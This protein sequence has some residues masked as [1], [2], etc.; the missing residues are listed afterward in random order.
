LFA[1]T[2]WP[3]NRDQR[4]LVLLMASLLLLPLVTAP[5]IGVKLTSLWTMSAWFLLPIV[6]LAPS[7]ATLSRLA[8]IRV[9]G[10]VGI[11]TI[12]C[13]AA[14]PLVAWT[15]F[16]MKSNDHRRFYPVAAKEVTRAWHAA[17]QRRLSIV[18]GDNL[19]PAVSFYSPDHPDSMITNNWR[20]WPW[21]TPDRLAQE[22]WVGV[23][24][25][26]DQ[27]CVDPMQRQATGSDV[28]RIEK[29]LSASFFGVAYA[30]TEII[31]FVVPP[32]T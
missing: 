15:N 1:T 11:V 26:K 13:L 7:R 8:A 23:C 32:K 20:Q 28:K 29:T 19:G 31:V 3:D 14:A 18:R 21:I 5:L 25:A 4:M 9:A 12:L 17:T 16:V 22:G 27:D 2:L 10:V 6:L 24:F 30:E